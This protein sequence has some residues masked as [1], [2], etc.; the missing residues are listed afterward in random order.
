M[1]KPTPMDIGVMGNGG[2]GEMGDQGMWYMGNQGVWYGNV[3]YDSCGD[4][5]CGN[6]GSP[7]AL[8]VISK[9][10]VQCWNCGG[11]GHFARE[12]KAKGKGKNG[13]YGNNGGK[14]K[15]RETRTCYVCNKEGHIAANCWSKG[16]TLG[17]Q[18]LFIYKRF[19]AFQPNT[20]S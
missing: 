19:S 1:M 4:V 6:C 12:C 18:K 3:W 9:A 13:M 15:G 8:D 5:T 2:L 14:G 16:L 7:H 11:Y 17:R 10:G 20:L